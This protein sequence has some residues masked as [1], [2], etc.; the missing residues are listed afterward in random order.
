MFH[1][2]MH[3]YTNIKDCKMLPVGEEIYVIS[4]AVKIF[5]HHDKKDENKLYMYEYL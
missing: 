4:A 3:T 1:S 5:N 2:F